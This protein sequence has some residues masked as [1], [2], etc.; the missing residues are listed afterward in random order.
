MPPEEAAMAQPV[1]EVTTRIDAAPEAV[2]DAMT[3]KDSAMFPGTEVDTDWQVGHPI[4]F[5]GEWKG[6]P[7]K[8]KGEIR[9]FDEARE[10]SFTHWSALSGDKDQPENYHLVRYVLEKQGEAT[11]VTLNQFNEGTKR[12]LDDATKAEFTRNWKMMLDGLK[13]S[14]EKMH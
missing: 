8:D 5:S 2:W 4:T 13:Q 11:K 3:R 6:K 10:L 14:V 12:D 1:I 9:A 7:F